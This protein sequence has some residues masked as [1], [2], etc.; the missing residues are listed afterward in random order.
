MSHCF[1]LDVV[2]VEEELFSGFVQKLF[3]TGEMGELEILYN[4]APLLT[5][6]KPGPLWIVKEN[7]E[8]EA[9]YIS[10]GMLEVQKTTTIVLADTAIRA[11]DID[12]AAALEAKERAEQALT[13]HGRDFNYAKAQGQ[14]IEAVAQLRALKKI[15][16]QFK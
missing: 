13:E 2:S 1:H 11:K 10:G 5:I 4:H 8:D 14:L 6:L 16:E 9:L 15:R 7:G 12:E 3:V